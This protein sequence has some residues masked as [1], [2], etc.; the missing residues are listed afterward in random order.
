LGGEHIVPASA[1]RMTPG[2][3]TAAIGDPALCRIGLAAQ[4]ELLIVGLGASAGVFGEV[5]IARAS[6]SININ[7]SSTTS[8]LPRSSS[9]A[10]ARAR[11][12]VTEQSRAPHMDGIVF[13]D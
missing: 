12:P 9:L 7:A 1:F 11:S 10:C 13:V 6:L 2:E 3:L 8:V 4:L 5:A